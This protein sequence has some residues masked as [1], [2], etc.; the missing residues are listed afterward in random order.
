MKIESIK[1]IASEIKTA[2]KL[3]KYWDSL[4]TKKDPRISGH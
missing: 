2:Q 3:P 1:H 4:M